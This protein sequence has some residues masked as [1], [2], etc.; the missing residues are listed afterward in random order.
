MEPECQ[1]RI[2]V[3][4]GK[5]YGSVSEISTTLGL[6]ALL[7]MCKC[8]I[9]N[10]PG[11]LSLRRMPVP[12]LVKLL[13]LCS[14]SPRS[15]AACLCVSR[16][17]WASKIQPFPSPTPSTGTSTPC[18]KRIFS[19][20][21][22]NLLEAMETDLIRVFINLSLLAKQSQEAKWEGAG[23]F[24]LPQD[25]LLSREFRPTVC[26]RELIFSWGKFRDFTFAPNT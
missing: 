20:L 24:F 18:I 7:P 5:T 10:V 21:S 23:F 6:Q 11:S 16:H 19:G 17:I 15:P 9:L 25:T 2:Q 4:P 26:S 13:S 12:S 8:L 22:N 14:F 1:Q 3:L